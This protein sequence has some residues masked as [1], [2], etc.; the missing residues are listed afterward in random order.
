MRIV[1]TPYAFSRRDL[2]V[3]PVT[4]KVP[5][6]NCGYFRIKASAWFALTVATSN[7]CACKTAIAPV[8]ATAISL[9]GT[10]ILQV[11]IARQ[12]KPDSTAASPSSIEREAFRVSIFEVPQPDRIHPG[13]FS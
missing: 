8:N 13:G 6:C 2:R 11:G 5:L 7:V 4:L 3:A 12:T 9:L 1:F 10:F